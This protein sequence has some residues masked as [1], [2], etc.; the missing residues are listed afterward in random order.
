MTAVEPRTAFERFLEAEQQKDLLRLLTCGSVDDGKSTLIG[1]LLYD[2]RNVFEDQVAAAAK[3]TRNKTAGA[4]DLSLLTDGL[5]AEREQGITID[6]AYRYFA[7]ARRK[8]IIA[9]TPGHEQYTR[10]MATGASTA[11]LAILLIDARQGVLAQSRRHAY[12]CALLGIPRYVV[13]VNK[14][15]LVDYDRGVFDRIQLDFSEFLDSIGIRDAY[16]LPMSALAG[17]NVVHGSKQMPWFRGSSLL[18]HLETVEAKPQASGTGFRMAV[19]R[20]V[21]PDLDFR[22]YAGQIASGMV[23]PGDIVTVLPSGF[24]SRVKRIVT[25]DAD[26][27]EA[28]TGQAVTIVLEDQLDIS[29]GDL[30]FSGPVKPHASQKFEAQV[31]WMDS[32]PLDARRRYLIKQTSRTVTAEISA[33]RHRVNIH[34]LAQEEADRL[35]MNAIGAV[36]FSVAKPIFFDVYSA[37]RATGAFIIIDPETNATAGAG[38]LTAAVEAKRSGPVTAADRMARWGHRGSIV[39][40][41][42]RALAQLVERKLFERGCAVA[43]A[44]SEA[45]A[46]VM[47]GAG[48]IAIIV[49][50]SALDTDA[51]RIVRALELGDV[52]R[53]LDRLTQG[54]GI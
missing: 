14:M 47:E 18:E 4:L 40:V 31:V 17:D 27:E 24:E 3:A 39:R 50:R 43:I 25:Y 10:N 5:R 22:G 41:R 23:S 6:V 35:E 36:E 12:I 46:L 37:N 20:V 11:D 28:Q 32:R 29:R 15:D 49:D 38:M 13:A 45:G 2:S 53:P 26:L 16:F 44:E 52:L 33:I 42:D 30:L 19:Q 34:T 1:R 51:A 21:R 48:M 54:G 8:F 7:T 9:D